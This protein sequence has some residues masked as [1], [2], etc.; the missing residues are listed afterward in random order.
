MMRCIALAGGPLLWLAACACLAT[1]AQGAPVRPDLDDLSQEMAEFRRAQIQSVSYGFDFALREKVETFEGTARLQVQLNVDSAPLSIDLKARTLHSVAVNGRAIQNI[2]QRNG[3]FDIPAE[4]LS[5]KPLE[6][7]VTYTGEYSKSGEGL[8]HFTDPVDDKE[9]LYTNLE[10]YGAHLVVPCFDQPDIK[11]P[12]TMTV[13]AP[14]N[15]VVIGN[16]RVASQSSAGEFQKVSFRPTP[17]LSTY[18]FFVGAG[19]Y[20]AWHD[21]H[22]GLPLALYAR[23]SLAKHFDP[24]RLFAETK[25]G[26]DYFNEF[27]QYPYPF[28]KY[29][30]VFA[31]E[32]NPGAMENP[33][34][35]TMNEYMI[36]RGAVTAENYRDR[37]NTLLHEMAHMW[38]GDLVTMTWWNDLWLNESFAT[39]SAFLAQNTMTK[40]PAIWQDFYGMKGWA[41]YQDQL[42][43]THPI[44]TD[45]PSARL[46][47]DNF[48]GITYAKGAAALKQLWFQVGPEAYAAGVAAYFK[49]FAW[50]NAT[51]AQFMDAIAQSSGAD[52]DAWT[53]AW[54]KTEGL[55][56]ISVDLDCMEGRIASFAVEHASVNAPRLSPHK[57]QVALFRMND[58]GVLEQN[59]VVPVA[60]AGE[61]TNV[62]GLADTPC[63]DFV[64]PNY[65]DMDYGLFFLDPHSYD[66]IVK[67]L[68]ALEDPFLRRMVWGTLSAM[69]RH[70][71]LRASEFMKLILANLPAEAEQ[72]VLEYLLGGRVINETLLLHLAPEERQEFAPRLLTILTEGRAS[73]RSGSDE[74]LLWHD[75]L[76]SLSCTPDAIGLLRPMLDG[77][78]LDQPRRWNI[79]G[80]LAVLGVK[81]TEALVEAELKRDPTDQGKRFAFGI[82]GA[83]PTADAKAAQWERL[84]DPELSLSLQRAGSG[85]F[86]NS[87]YPELSEPYVGKWLERIRVIDWNAEEHRIGIWFDN[88][89]PPIY[90]PEFLDR[91]KREFAAAKLP[92]RASR[93]WQEANDQIERVIAIRAY[94]RRSQDTP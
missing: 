14:A 62:R 47:M 17:P 27:F 85:S 79:V 37:N 87:L 10:P 88:L 51:R 60:Y 77:E 2:I 72:G 69:V 44:E 48:D 76:V 29:D 9:Y 50:Q 80:R 39:F 57:T 46:A 64:Y 6:I 82:R 38:F 35:V 43:T 34:A 4:H 19:G 41:Y 73:A 93:A 55:A 78:T 74:W 67:R 89:F 30:H 90:T 92:P 8:C 20:Q 45:V 75:A 31:P 56:Q 84:A 61:R 26:L 16:M 54:L 23:A 1:Q 25:A 15:W 68:T 11:A 59:G 63:P 52:L 22:D 33:G 40:D 32:L 81:D 94:D 53:E 24:E 21:E 18:L 42:S 28:D 3:S 13:E 65:G 5:L 70:E 7:V 58:R 49:E 91:S 86:H 83:I 36:F 66:T 71:R 12:S